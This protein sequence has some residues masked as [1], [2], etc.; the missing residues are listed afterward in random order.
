MTL[1]G[2]LLRTA[3]TNFAD[4]PSTSFVA[5]TLQPLHH[6]QGVTSLMVLN[7]SPNGSLLH[8][9]S[10]TPEWS[11]LPLELTTVFSLDDFPFAGFS[12]ILQQHLTASKAPLLVCRHSNFQYFQELY[13]SATSL[14]QT[15]SPV[16]LIALVGLSFL[17]HHVADALS[18][19]FAC[20]SVQC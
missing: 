10:A 20:I 9:S 17:F 16:V 14:Q 7:L 11:S 19:L 2:S 3:C 1:I 13:H 4:S 15:P 5:F 18:M 12:S 8:Y 6:S